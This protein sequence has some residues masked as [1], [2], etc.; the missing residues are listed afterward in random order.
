MSTAPEVIVHPD[1]ELLTAALAARAITVI[2]DAQ[3]A[4]GLGAVVLTGGST[5]TAVLEQLRLSPARDA[6]DWSRL[7]V[8]WGD[9]R[10]LPLG[11]PERN[12]TQA[13]A[14]LLDH[15]PVDPA[16]VFAMAASDSPLGYDP[17]AAAAGYA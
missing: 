13:R 9:E 3:T 8:Y 2:V 10:F 5:G 1:K 16:R 11:D 17:D 7:D 14:A 6:V 15:V 4:R 12:E